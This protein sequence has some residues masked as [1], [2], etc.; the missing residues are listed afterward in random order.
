MNLETLLEIPMLQSFGV[1]L[2][3]FLV[4]STLLYVAKRYAAR[5]SMDKTVRIFINRLLKPSFILLLLLVLRSGLSIEDYYLPEPWNA[6]LEHGLT[7]ALIANFGW[8][9]S[10]M[11]LATRV[12]ILRKY[13][14]EDRTN[15]HARMVHTQIDVIM[16]VFSFIVVILTLAMILLTFEGAA[17]VGESLLAS[18]GVAGIILGFAAQKTIGNL[19]AGIQ[20]AIAQ[21]IRIEDSVIIEGEWGWIEEINLTYV[22]VRIWDLRR[23]VVPITHFTEQPFQ[24]WTRN[25]AEIIGPVIIYTDYTVPIAEM[26]EALKEI[27]QRTD[28]WNGRVCVLQMIDCRE[29]TLELRALVSG[30]DAPGTWELRCFVREALV[31]WLREHHAY[32]LPRTRMEMSRKD[33]APEFNKS[34]C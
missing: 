33:D 32:A 29:Q 6:R 3:V 14:K 20:I 22:V 34:R 12:T 21:P 13:N 16:K 17:V 18:A 5:L 7:I 23:L 4:G 24:N 9:F 15:V 28:H 25:D 19:F 8:F 30:R 11:L 27:V 10:R 31:E 26:R 1:S 2:S